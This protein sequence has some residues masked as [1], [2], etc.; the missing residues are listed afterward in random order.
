MFFKMK[1]FLLVIW[2]I[3]LI[4]VLNGCNLDNLDFSNLSD[5]V[6]LSPS[7]V[8]PLGNA[9]IT[10][11]DL[12]R[13][14]NKEKGPGGLISLVYRQENLINYKLSDL[15]NLPNEQRFSSLE[16][17]VGDISP[18][19][20][21]RKK[22]ITLS[23]LISTLDGELESIRLYSGMSFPF[24]AYSYPGPDVL[25]D[26]GQISDFTFVSV[27][28]G[29]LDFSLENKFKVPVT[30]TGSLFD[31]GN[32][33]EIT[34]FTFANVA[35]GVISKKSVSLAGHKISNKIEFRM[36][37]FETAGSIIPV[38]INMDDYLRITFDLKGLKISSGNVKIQSQVVDGST[39]ALSFVFPEPNMKAFSAILKKGTLKLTAKNTTK[40]TGNVNLSLTEIK[41]S[42][43]SILA[44]IPL[45]GNVTSIDLSGAEINFA[46]DAAIPFNQIPYSYS[47]QL[48][49]SA[50]YVDFTSTDALKMDI[51][52]SD[53]EF[54]SV[55]GDFG[56]T[57]IQID[58]GNFELEVLNKLGE[59]FKVANPTLS[60]LLHNSIGIPAE[61]NLNMTANGIPAEVNQNMTTK[62]KQGH[63]EA[64]ERNPSAFIIPVPNDIF[65][66]IANGTIEYNKQN[67][68]IVNFIAMPPNTKISYSGEIAFNKGNVVTSLNPNFINAESAFSVDIAMDL[69]M[70][71]QINSLS[72]SDTSGISGKNFDKVESA[73][74]LI[75][76][77][78]GIPLDLDMQMFFIDTIS[79]Q[80][81]GTSKKTRM[82]SAAKKDASGNY[83]P[84]ESQHSFILDKSEIENLRKA[85]AVVFSGT[86]ISPLGENEVVRIFSTSK[87][88]LNLVMKSTLNL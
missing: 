74:L 1:Q 68:N 6:N 30:I 55:V 57:I 24:P 9:S 5:E 82:L 71:L 20:I 62:S 22:D 79:K 4:V 31:S 72:F 40:L 42:G 43:S 38:N 52:I 78:N 39:G 36:K 37:T 60:L 29:T 35:P 70:E 87:I 73:K 65:S 16:K 13:T 84:L 46:S 85:N 88:E 50:G 44:N 63:F 56:K 3:L 53:L 48:E 25:F 8:A 14:G 69:P 49:N 47:V 23:E 77:K 17:A 80:Q 66:G 58:P 81:Y 86:V 75:N 21:S 11:W 61:V 27:N 32:K 7:L 28:E 26:L 18:G 12:F 33:Q 19:T 67:S 83:I 51:S 45:S 41:K 59:D 15:V 54:Q 34:D 10:G 64:L 2:S 76:S